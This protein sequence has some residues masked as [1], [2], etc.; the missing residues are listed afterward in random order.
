MDKSFFV[1]E[2]CISCGL[3]EKICPV[4]NIR[5]KNDKP[6]W[7]HN[8]EMCFRCLNYC[9][10]DAIQFGKSTIEKKRYK[11]PFIKVSDF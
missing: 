4:Q 5:L 7:T 6:T 3:C 11:N 1:D 2:N 9:P 10:K 8:C